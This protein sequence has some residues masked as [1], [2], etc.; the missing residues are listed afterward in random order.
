M[1]LSLNRGQAQRIGQRI[2]WLDPLARGLITWLPMDEPGGTVFF[3]AT[4]QAVPG[5]AQGT[6]IRRPD[7]VRGAVDTT[8]GY[9]SVP[10]AG[11]LASLAQTFSIAFWVN[12]ASRS[13]YNELITK[14][15]GAVSNPF[16]VRT[17]VTTGRLSLLWGNG[18]GQSAVF[19]SGVPPLGVWT[20]V[21]ATR[22]PNGARMYMN[23]FLAPGGSAVAG[24]TP[25]AGT[26]PAYIGY[27]NDNF[28]HAAARIADVRIYNTELSATDVLALYQQ[29]WRPFLGPARVLVLQTAAPAVTC[30]QQQSRQVQE[31]RSYTSGRRWASGWRRRGSKRPRAAR[32]KRTPPTGRCRCPKAG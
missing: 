29:P 23:G 11:L 6:L 14:C 5:T 32:R 16:E 30:P 1:V 21:V 19:S 31:T 18:S 12:I 15:T 3:D 20:H 26:T 4:G 25:T 27:R 2:N 24:T 8:T 13:G 10:N 28:G 17:E 7:L 22:S 9:I